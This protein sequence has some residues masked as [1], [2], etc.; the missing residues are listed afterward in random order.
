MTYTHV[1][2]PLITLRCVHVCWQQRAE[3]CFAMTLE[4]LWPNLVT[5]VGRGYGDGQVPHKV[6]IKYYFLFSIWFSSVSI[7]DYETNFLVPLL[8]LILFLLN[9][10]LL[11]IHSKNGLEYVLQ[12][13]ST[14]YN[15]ITIIEQN[16][17]LK[18]WMFAQLYTYE[19]TSQSKVILY[20]L[21]FP[22][23]W[24][25]LYTIFRFSAFVNQSCGWQVKLYHSNVSICINVSFIFA[26]YV[27][28]SR[29]ESIELEFN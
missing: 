29:C 20:C 14:Y 27:C 2:W 10:F 22:L 23:C 25:Y 6:L 1:H 4:S 28:L 13:C 17:L 11:P 12:Y 21:A 5:A 24:A 9:N 8:C 15:C 16:S 7:Y 26:I 3:R 18:I 19:R